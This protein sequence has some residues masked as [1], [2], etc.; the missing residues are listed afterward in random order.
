[1]RSQIKTH[2]QL[3]VGLTLML[4]FAVASAQASPFPAAQGEESAIR[5]TLAAQETA[6]NHGDIPAFMATYEDSPET[7]FIGVSINKGSQRILER[8]KKSYSTP[9]LMGQ[10]SFHEVE[11]RL[12][13]ASTGTAEYAI[14][15]GRFHLERTVKGEGTKDEGIFSLVW[16]K[17]PTGW[18]I[19]LDHTS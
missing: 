13:P 10:L 5:T 2:I 8:Y 9:A 3:I 1:M 14:V 6:W 18:K 16:H 11:V 4:A 19:I 15:T 7:T 12:L 17:T